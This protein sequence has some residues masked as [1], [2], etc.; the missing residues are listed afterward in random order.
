MENDVIFGQRYTFPVTVIASL[1]LTA[2]L[3]AATAGMKSPPLGKTSHPAEAVTTNK[4][5]AYQ[6]DMAQKNNTG[7]LVSP[8]FPEPVLHW[9]DLITR[10]ANEHGLDPNLVAAVILQESAGN[11]AAY[12]H[13]GAVGLMQVMPRDGLAA[14]FMCPAGPCFK[15]RPSISDLNDPEFNVAYGVKMLA[16]LISR[17]G[18]ER[19]GLRAYGPMDVGYYYSDKVLSL[20][21]RYQ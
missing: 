1:I 9:C 11:P 21:N 13:S 16:G 18:S 5:V 4:D 14:S 6:A 8:N 17:L 3:I 2:F 10:Q 15:D 7:C 12:S 19:D 20:Y